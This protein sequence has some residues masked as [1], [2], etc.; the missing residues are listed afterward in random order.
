[1]K[2]LL[3]IAKV[4]RDFSRHDVA[5]RGLVEYRG[6]RLS[7]RRAL[8]YFSAGWPTQ[9]VDYFRGS[10]LMLALSTPA[11]SATTLT[12]GELEASGGLSGVV[13]VVYRS[14]AAV[15]AV[16]M[17]V[18]FDPA[19]Y[20]AAGATAGELAE[21]F[22]VDSHLVEP[23]RLR[24]VVGAPSNAPLTDGIVFRVPLTAVDEFASFYPVVL[25]DF[26]LS[27]AGSAAV[28]GN[29]AP[30]VR[31]LGLASGGRVN[32]SGGV[33]LSVE[34]GATDANVARVEY[35]VGGQ[36]IGESGAS[37]FG[38]VWTP[39]GSGPFT[40]SAIAFDSNGLQTES[41][42]IGIVVTNVGTLAVKGLYSGLV[43]DEPFAFGTNGYVQFST[44]KK[45][46]FS[47]KLMLGG[48]T[49]AGSGKFAA[50]GTATVVFKKGGLTLTLQQF[51]TNLVDQISGQLTDG[52]LNGAV[53]ENATFVA[54]VVAD[55]AIAREAGE[56]GAYTIVLP[57]GDAALGSGVGFAKVSDGG[58][59]TAAFTLADGE[60]A[61][62]GTFLSKDGAWPLFA[63]LYRSKGVLTGPLEFT[64]EPGVSDFGGALDWAGE[65]FA[66]TLDAVGSRYSAPAPYERMLNLANVAG[67]AVFSAGAVERLLTVSS[68]NVATPFAS[69]LKLKLVP[70]T[71]AFSG[72]FQ[73]QPFTG[74]VFQK[75]NLGA[76][77]FDG[78][79]VTLGP[80]PDYPPP[81]AA[82]PQG[83]KPLPSVAFKSPK[84][85]ARFEQP[86]EVTGVAKA[87]AGVTAVS[88]QVLHGGVL[89]AP[90]PATGTGA[91]SVSFAPASGAGGFYTVFV[92]A[93]D[94]A[95]H[96]SDVA[97]RTFF[98]VVPSPLTVSISGPG[99]VT[100]GFAGTTNREIGATY[101]LTAK[102]QRGHTFTG[103]TG[104][105]SSTAPT[106]TF[107]MAAGFAVQ[108]GFQ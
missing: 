38:I 23:G 9:V 37:P 63:S 72:K 26:A 83:V 90:Q 95:Q 31:L 93:E 46:A 70:K 99:E 32:G 33:S 11:F 88:Y 64:E 79:E 10:L 67:N 42:S 57:S 101:T 71:G 25:T 4:V 76:G 13:P 43:R 78:G 44:T 60:K 54:D 39:P 61:T 107:T 27:T 97:Q 82:L 16:Q 12:V 74:V 96:E 104:S 41:R 14:D 84:D 53:I 34:A 49:F 15:A 98:Y 100:K 106:I 65:S 5:L 18:L 77:F 24:V 58:K 85:R 22:R 75:Q 29:I 1:M 20:S 59:I 94:A 92:K 50:D 87:K 103:W 47:T 105:V 48:K 56:R 8:S 40:I 91:W 45:G 66:R 62:Q 89:S 19:A 69:D 36:K 73:G 28:V 6:G 68:A 52:T 21:A 81:P 80:N 2:L 7:A 86:T 17:D 102:P 55:R 30:R 35:Y 51:A 3:D 108:A